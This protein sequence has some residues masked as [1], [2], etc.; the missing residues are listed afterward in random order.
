MKYI[1]SL[2][3]KEL[4]CI[5]CSAMSNSLRPHGLYVAH[6]ALSMKSLSKNTGEGCH[7]F[8]QGN[9]PDPGKI[10]PTYPALQTDA[11]PSELLGK[12][13]KELTTPKSSSSVILA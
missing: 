1:L 3:F 9:L 5:S 4:E 2:A 12:P 11:L 10:E 7:F 6:Q 8:L 13:F